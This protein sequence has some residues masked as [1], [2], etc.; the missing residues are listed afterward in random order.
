M[1]AMALIFAFTAT[2]VSPE[3]IGVYKTLQQCEAATEMQS[4]R[5]QCFFID[6]KKGLVDAKLHDVNGTNLK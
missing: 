1:F 5:T 4:S 2:D 6:P 3:V